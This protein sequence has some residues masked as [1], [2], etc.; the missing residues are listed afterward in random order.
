MDRHRLDM[1]HALTPLAYSC[2][3]CG[4]HMRM[5]IVWPFWECPH[6]HVRLIPADLYP[7][8]EAA[9]APAP[10][11]QPTQAPP[12]ASEQAKVRQD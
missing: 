7:I 12:P 4:R 5:L 9:P 3:A 10:D 11:Q 6:C 2:R 8:V 1:T